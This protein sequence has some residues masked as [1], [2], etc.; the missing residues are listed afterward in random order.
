[1]NTLV[2][3]RR[4]AVAV[5]FFAFLIYCPPALGL[6][7]DEVLVLANTNASS[8]L[9]LAE[10]YMEKRKIPRDHLLKLWVMD[11]EEC[12]R[13]DY[14]R[15]IASPVRKYLSR[16]AL[17]GKI[18]CLLIMYG[19]PLKIAAPEMNGD[20]RREY[21]RIKER[22][23]TLKARLSAL[24]EGK[25]KEQGEIEKELAEVQK[26]C[27]RTAKSDQ[28]AS[29]DSEISLVLE[30]NHSLEGWIPNP[31]FAGYHPPQLIEKR[32]T[33]LFVSRL[34]GPSPQIVRRVIDDS[35]GAERSGLK[36]KAYFDARWPRTHEKAGF[37][38]KSGYQYYDTSIYRAADVVKTGHT[39]AVIVNDK[40]E[41]FQMGECPHAAL[42]C[43]W[44]H[45]GQ[46]VDAFTWAKGSVGYHIASAECQT[47]KRSGSG[48]WCK[49][50]LEE[51]IAATLGPVNEPYV[52]AF[53]VP[54]LFFRFLLDG[55]WTLAEC[56]ALSKPFLSW[57]MVLIGDPLYRP[58]K[59]PDSIK[60]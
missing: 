2:N 23:N 60:K 16:K 21:K 33:T 43:G 35:L 37:K 46:Y 3:H 52:Q 32:D 6:Q 36:G 25:E 39:M 58:F 47:L 50:M 59:G 34:D 28:R 4:L 11:K 15:K 24:S 9:A 8:S 29:L 26:Q 42:Y 13:R 22:E 27:E 57:Q 55:Y 53:P 5:F 41:L 45:L 30:R 20:E 19:L 40:P 51:G 17:E 14:E 38:G 49:R 1:M 44:Y 56:Y 7:P 18:R 48:V 54:E 10:Y 12:T 31:F